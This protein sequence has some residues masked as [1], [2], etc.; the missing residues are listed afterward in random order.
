MPSCLNNDSTLA[1]VLKM[2]AIGN[3]HFRTIGKQLH[4]TLVDLRYSTSIIATA[5]EY[6]FAIVHSKIVARSMFGP[7][8][9]FPTNYGFK[10][11]IRPACH[12]NL[13]SLWYQTQLSV[14]DC[15]YGASRMTLPDT[16]ARYA[17][18]LPALRVQETFWKL[19]GST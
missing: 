14:S 10:P 15:G 7:H 2:S 16:S 5:V 18:M 11:P 6:H 9:P 19:E 4:T 12:D 8:Y 1:S 17:F 13:P 3:N